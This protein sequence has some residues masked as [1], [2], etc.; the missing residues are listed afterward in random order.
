MSLTV[1]QSRETWQQELV[2][3]VRDPAQLLE[4]L[5]LPQS[6]LAGATR[7]SSEFQ[8]M[9][10]RSFLSRMEHGNA[11]D[12]L[13][14][15][16]LPVSR[17]LDN[18]RGYSD[19]P[20]QEASARTAPGLIKKYGSRALL[21]A[22]GSCAINCRYC[23]RRA[24]PYE[25]EPRQLEDWEPA[26]NALEADSA[27]NEVILS[28]GDPLLLSDSRLTKLLERLESIPHVSMLR[29]HSR[30]PIVLPSRLTSALLGRLL[31]SRL[32]PVVV[33]HSNH[34]NEVAGDCEGALRRLVRAG[35]PTLNQTVL[36]RDINDDSGTLVDLSRRL[37]AVGVM[38]YYLHKLD[39]VIGTSHFAVSEE[40]GRELI[41]EIRLQLPGYAVPRFVVEEPGEPHK[42]VL[43]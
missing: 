28:G 25:T 2:D 19:D 32:Q 35:I 13:L 15:Q 14:L 27:V 6:L 3:A 33:V 11:A 1:L 41:S 26:L 36:L 7:A 22:A 12:P 16:V 20:L 29:I 39:R 42:T 9:V 21:V 10:T 5:G 43:A 31:E 34:P 30:I 4:I 8:L 40:R 17:E 37:T 24:Y 18:I 38:P 23:F